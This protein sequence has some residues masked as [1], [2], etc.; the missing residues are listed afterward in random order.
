MFDLRRILRDRNGEHRI[1]GG[2]RS[3]CYRE[4]QVTRR[5]DFVGVGARSLVAGEVLG[6]LL[7]SK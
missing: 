3:I 2:P 5:R 1:G 4:V 6:L 7:L